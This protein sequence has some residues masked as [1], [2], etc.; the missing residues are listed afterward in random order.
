M[1]RLIGNK[2]YMNDKLFFVL[3]ILL[4]ITSS[5]YGIG[6][7]LYSVLYNIFSMV[8]YSF[9]EPPISFSFTRYVKDGI[10]FFL[11]LYFIKLNSFNISKNIVKLITAF[12][13]YILL[14]MLRGNSLMYV[15]GGIRCFLSVILIYCYFNKYSFDKKLLYGVYSS[16]IVTTILNVIAVV[17][18]INI[19]G[20][21]NF[22]GIGSGGYRYMGLFTSCYTLGYFSLGS[23][24]YLCKFYNVFKDKCRVINMIILALLLFLSIASGTRFTIM[25]IIVVIMMIFA[26]NLKFNNRDKILFMLTIGIAIIA[27]IYSIVVSQVDRGETMASGQ[28]RVDY[29]VYIYNNYDIIELLMGRGFGY[30][31]NAAAQL[32]SRGDITP[33]STLNAMVAQFGILGG[34]IFIFY[35]INFFRK[36]MKNSEKCFFVNLG[37]IS[38]LIVGALMA[39]NLFEQQPFILYT[40][41]ALLGNYKEE[42]MEDLKWIQNH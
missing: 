30:G 41:V 40:A 17:I 20:N 2:K 35:F 39:T 8:T 6:Y 7:F 31:T 1:E 14:G 19:F 38:V 36:M 29:W 23:T 27:I 15:V 13:F 26:Q 24:I 34:I 22:L 11:A 21:K 4:F 33:D 42:N 25:G 3:F 12:M 32:G 5:I 16:I 28:G 9:L 18:Q 10:L 37:I